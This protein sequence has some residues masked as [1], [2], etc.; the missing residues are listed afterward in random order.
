MTTKARR[1]LEDS[2]FAL[3]QLRRCE[4]S[5]ATDDHQDFLQEWRVH[6]FT[7]VALVRT[8]GYVLEKVDAQTDEVWARLVRQQY[9]GWKS[10]FPNPAIYW[11]FIKAER[12]FVVKQY[13]IR[14]GDVMRAV[15][16]GTTSITIADSTYATPSGHAIVVVPTFSHGRFKGRGMS[17]TVEAAADWWQEQLDA[18]DR[19]HG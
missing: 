17:A 19:Q 1:V 3:D 8:V 6:W 16:T 14:I 10:S 5:G 11:E 9:Q 4:S 15:G 18:L 2:R 13:L 12:D 7:A